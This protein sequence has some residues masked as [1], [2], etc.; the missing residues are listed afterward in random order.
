MSI[1]NASQIGLIGT[2]FFVSLPAMIATLFT[3][4]ISFALNAEFVILVIFKLLF[5]LDID[6]HAS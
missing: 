2:N 6:S 1:P 3:F 5:Y 4:A